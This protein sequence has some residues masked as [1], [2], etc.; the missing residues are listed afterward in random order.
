MN[1]TSIDIPD[2]TSRQAAY[3]IA[4]SAL[5]DHYTRRQL[6]DVHESSEK[7]HE[8]INDDPI[9]SERADTSVGTIDSGDRRE[10]T[11]SGESDAPA[12]LGGEGADGGASDEPDS[13]PVT[14]GSTDVEPITSERTESESGESKS[15]PV[16]AGFYYATHE[17]TRGTN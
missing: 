6:P 13:T 5:D 3:R 9:P 14:T 11:D 1:G 4:L 12:E 10:T 15:E 2:G 7:E 16:N 8:D 17:A